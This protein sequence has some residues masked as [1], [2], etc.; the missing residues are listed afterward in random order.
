MNNMSK[1]VMVAILVSGCAANGT[2]KSNDDPELTCQDRRVTVNH[3]PAFLVAYPEYLVAC[4]GQ[5]IVVNVIPS[6]RPG[7]ATTAPADRSPGPSDWLRSEN[8][9]GGQ[10]VIQIPEGTAAGE[11][12]YSITIEGVGTL[13][14]RVRISR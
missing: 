6:V 9:K 11:Y 14:P 7:S 10:T 1:F 8:L 4:A 12:K 3:A 5:K 13:D 2:V